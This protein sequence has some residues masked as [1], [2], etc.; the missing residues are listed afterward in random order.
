MFQHS[1]LNCV[2]KKKNLNA[3]KLKIEIPTQECLKIKTLS[4]TGLAPP[5]TIA[6]K[7]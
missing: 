2:L 6:I 5:T 3:S 4:E 1:Q 7:I